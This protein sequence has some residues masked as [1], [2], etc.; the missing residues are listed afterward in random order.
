MA[1]V[2]A[3]KLVGRDAEFALL[4]QSAEQADGGLF[5][6]ALVQGEAGIGKSRLVAEWA[7]T[8]RGR[9][10]LVIIGRCVEVG[11]DALPH[12]PVAGMLRDL[13]RQLGVHRV[14]EL[15]G[16]EWPVLT[17]LVP[18]LGDSE[19]AVS[20]VSQLRLFDAVAQVLRGL[21]ADGLVVVVLEDMHW[22]DTSSQ[23]LNGCCWC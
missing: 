7:K 12:A 17:V 5:S 11:G 6:I 21:T 8:A 2:A 10:R 20:S 3:V 15:A 18:E 22:S 13:A 19:G 23:G 9:G 1:R 16:G 4:E 14:R